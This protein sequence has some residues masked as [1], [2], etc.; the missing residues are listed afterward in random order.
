MISIDFVR[1]HHSKE[2]SKK[3]SALPIKVIAPKSTN[4]I[5]FPE[6]K[7]QFDVIDPNKTLVLFPSNKSKELSEFTEKELDNIESVL[8]VDCT[9]FQTKAIV[10]EI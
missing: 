7:K 9:W 6:D 2:K 1:I 5:Y 3:S 10:R 4:I 8:V